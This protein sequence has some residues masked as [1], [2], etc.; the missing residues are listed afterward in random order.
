[1]ARYHNNV[2]GEPSLLGPSFN[3]YVRNIFII[4]FLYN[5][6]VSGIVYYLSRTI[7]DFK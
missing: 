7:I 1:V 6:C 4:Q 5:I 2:I 3:Y